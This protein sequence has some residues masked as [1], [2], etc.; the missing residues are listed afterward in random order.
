MRPHQVFASMS[1]ER[2]A[3]FFEKIGETS[4]AM[5]RQAIQAASAAL[6]SRPSYLMKQPFERRAAALRRALARVGADAVAEELLAVYFLEC[7][8]ELLLEWLE[9]VGVEH[10]D[11]TLKEDSPAEPE[12]AALGKAVEAFRAKDEDPDRELLLGAFAAQS[13][14][15]WSGLDALLET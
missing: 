14:I 7:R 1:A 13:A 4:P 6:K 5:L 3:A 2:A 15:Q 12:P 8:K 11:G 9:T 10:E